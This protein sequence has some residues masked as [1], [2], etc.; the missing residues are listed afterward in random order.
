[1]PNYIATLLY[2]TTART[3]A[4]TAAET[5]TGVSHASAFASS[6]DYTGGTSSKIPVHLVLDSPYKIGLTRA[7]KMQSLN[8]KWILRDSSWRVLESDISTVTAGNTV[9]D[10]AIQTALQTT[11]TEGT[12]LTPNQD[13]LSMFGREWYVKVKTDP[14]PGVVD[15]SPNGVY[16]YNGG[17]GGD[18]AVLRL[19]QEYDEDLLATV[20]RGAEIK[21]LSGNGYGTYRFSTVGRVNNL[22]TN[23]TFGAFTYASGA[24]GGV[25]PYEEGGFEIGGIVNGDTCHAYHYR[26]GLPLE[27]AVEVV[28]IFNPGNGMVFHWEHTWTPTT[29]SWKVYDSNWAIVA[30]C[31]TTDSV[32]AYLGATWRFNAWAYLANPSAET[33]LAFFNYGWE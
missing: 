7:I 1:M 13:N 4:R 8:C 33:R 5:I 19:F 25:E 14:L 16:Y 21:S 9:R 3:E 23:P 30:N 27:E 11:F 6:F 31:S 20:W 17:I 12:E 10:T 22:V 32:D 2:P 15:P 18:V 29:R 26:T 24:D 28:Q